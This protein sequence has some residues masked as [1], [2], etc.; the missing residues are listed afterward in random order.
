MRIDLPKRHRRYPEGVLPL[1]NV[2]FLLL[3]FFMLAGRIEPEEVL[4]V[5]PPEVE[6]LEG[7]PADPEAILLAADGR[8]AFG[9][10]IMDEAALLDAIAARPPDAAPLRLKAD[11]AVEAVAVLALLARLRAAGVAGVELIAQGAAP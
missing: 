4:P 8:L 10:R 3:V 2:V 9:G 6:A 11:G 1:V 7:A 5:D